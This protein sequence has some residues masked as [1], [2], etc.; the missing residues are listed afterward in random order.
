[1][2]QRSQRRKESSRWWRREKAYRYLRPAA[3]DL[4]SMG[5]AHRPGN[6]QFGERCNFLRKTLDDTYVTDGPFPLDLNRNLSK[7]YKGK[8]MNVVEEMQND[9]ETRHPSPSVIARLMGLDA[10]PPHMVY[11]KQSGMHKY[12]QKT[13]GLQDKLVFHDYCSSGKV[14]N[15]YQEFKDVFEIMETSKVEK[16]SGK[17]LSK[18]METS[19]GSDTHVELVRHSFTDAE[20]FSNNETIDDSEASNVASEVLDHEKA[21]AMKF[22]QEPNSLFLNHFQDVK[23]ISLTHPSDITILKP[24]ISTKHKGYELKNTSGRRAEKCTLVQKDH[25]TQ[26]PESSSGNF[27]QKEHNLSFSDK[28]LKSQ[29]ADKMVAFIN[30]TQIVILRPSLEKTEKSDEHIVLPSSFGNFITHDRGHGEFRCCRAKSLNAEGRDWPKFNL[31]GTTRKKATCSSEM[32]RNITKA[33]GNDASRDIERILASRFNKYIS[34]DS[35]DYMSQITQHK[36][37][38]AAQRSLSDFTDQYKRHNK[39]VSELSVNREGRRRLSQRWKT[40]H[41]FGDMALSDRGSN[42]L[43]EMLSLSDKDL[44]KK[45]TDSSITRKISGERLARDG[46]LAE[47]SCSPAT[48][49]KDTSKNGCNF[50]ISTHPASSPMGLRNTRVSRR[51]KPGAYDNFST[52]NNVL[53]LG[54]YSSVDENL[55]QRGRFTRRKSKCC[56]NVP[57]SCTSVKPEYKLALSD[58]HVHSE[59]SNKFNMRNLH[60]EN[61]RVHDDA[62]SHKEQLLDNRDANLHL[63]NPEDQESCNKLESG[64]PVRLKELEHPSPVSVLE[65]PASEGENYTIGSCDGVN[66]DLQGLRIQLQLLKLESEDI[67]ISESGTLV[68]GNDDTGG[69]HRSPIEELRGMLEELKDEEDREFSYLVDV[70]IDSGI[71]CANWDRV[72]DACYMPEYPVCPDVFE[73]LE[74]KYGI[75]VEWSSSER[76]LLFDLINV[77]LTE[78]LAPCMDLHPWVKSKKKFGPMCARER[79]VEEAWLMIARLRKKLSRGKPE[80]KVLDTM[81]FDIEDDIDLIGREIEGLIKEELLQELVTD[82][83]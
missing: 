41:Q 24:S 48:S 44:L 72:F 70:L 22:L 74:R 11:D 83:I 55:C 65:Q 53:S 2:D 79:L 36:N 5:R 80:D 45:I 19:K 6:D 50:P 58:D 33:M 7:T 12:F 61:S 3:C 16:N 67:D 66:V 75:I 28:M 57:C 21:L 59:F 26:K 32:A 71:G 31:A 18:G 46:M 73:K 82:F 60:E 15:E 23:S 56:S 34:S 81:W 63:V 38:K 47:R 29:Y 77:V 62:I 1:M 37:Y 13:S 40:A 17:R 39:T 64:S 9:K 42:T 8:P 10:L 30:P 69:V 4:V 68:L 49:N 35:I 20:D 51:G 25:S 14:R 43:A 27:S 78:I 76:K 52:L 54:T